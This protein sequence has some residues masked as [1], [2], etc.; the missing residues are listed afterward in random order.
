MPVYNEELWL[1]AI[2]ERVLARPEVTQIVA[3]DDGSSDG[4]WRKLEE[5]NERELRLRIIRHENNQG[6]GAA[7]QTGLKEISAPLVLIQDADLEYSPSDY[8]KLLEPILHDHADVVYGS[9][10]SAGRNGN[11]R[12]HTFGNRAITW[13]LNRM[14]GLR[15]SDG[16]TCYKL[17]PSE[18]DLYWKKWTGDSLRKRIE[19]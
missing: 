13:V 18:L 1:D 9:R 3:V 2:L 15:L 17:F 4:S 8:P 12:W 16:F 5:W 14:T 11:P 10:F 7:I 19:K 6:K